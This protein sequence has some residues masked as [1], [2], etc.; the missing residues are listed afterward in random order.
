MSEHEQNNWYNR[1]LWIKML[2]IYIGIEILIKGYKTSGFND[3]LNEQF[4]NIIL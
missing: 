1:K 3:K 2:G 4:G